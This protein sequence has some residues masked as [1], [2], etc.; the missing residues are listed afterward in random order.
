MFH[1]DNNSVIEARLKNLEELNPTDKE[2]LTFPWQEMR[3]DYQ[4]EL[5]CSD[6][7]WDALCCVVPKPFARCLGLSAGNVG[8]GLLCCS[9]V[10]C[11][12]ICGGIIHPEKLYQEATEVT[13]ALFQSEAPKA[14]CAYDPSKGNLPGRLRATELIYCARLSLLAYLTK[15][16]HYRDFV[17]KIREEQLLS[18]VLSES[19]DEV[20]SLFLFEFLTS[21]FNPKSDERY[22][23]S[24]GAS[25]ALNGMNLQLETQFQEERT[26]TCG[27]IATSKNFIE[28]GGDL[29]IC[30]QGTVETEDFYTSFNGVQVPFDPL[31]DS[32]F[33]SGCCAGNNA[34]CTRCCFGACSCFSRKPEDQIHVHAGFY[35]AFL[36]VKHDIELVI[37][38]LIDTISTKPNKNVRLVITGHSLGGALAN[39]CTGW[40]VKWFEKRGGV[41]SN[42][43]VLA[44]T[45]G[46]PKVGNPAYCKFIDD[47]QYMR[48]E[49]RGYA[50]FKTYRFC[51][52]L[53]P[54][55]STPPR[56][57]GYDHCFAM[58]T[59][60]DKGELF[61]VKKGQAHDTTVAGVMRALDR[62]KGLMMFHDIFCYL[63]RVMH[64]ADRINTQRKRGGLLDVFGNFDYQK[65]VRE[66]NFLATF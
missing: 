5:T 35:N 23:Y 44:V 27:Y 65:V 64:F 36:S 4:P 10:L 51:T 39:L 50:V 63:Q 48:W 56:S 14:S 31:N 6:C 33:S 28:E 17:P 59:V 61:F 46:Q 26:S 12:C 42:F 3:G 32:E 60:D 49:E 47:N 37:T 1:P 34:T 43:R 18:N 13:N 11:Q 29:I 57:M 7:I 30:F 55:P 16:V 9:D 66:P 8:K 38:D 45:F 15:D 24:K 40:I 19:L 22:G 2:K 52:M 54:V 41:P 20:S 58:V 53:D 21:L 25:V 62:G